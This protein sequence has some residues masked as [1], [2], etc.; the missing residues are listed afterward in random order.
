MDIE[1]NALALIVLDRLLVGG[2]LAQLGQRRTAA[3]FRAIQES[4]VNVMRHAN[5]TRVSVEVE[6]GACE[7]LAVVEDD[8]IGIG[9]GQLSQ[10]H[11][12]GLRGMRERLGALGGSVAVSSSAGAG[13][14][15]EI[16]LP[17]RDELAPAPTGRA[18]SEQ[19]LEMPIW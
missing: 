3:V 18:V 2:Q 6:I 10:V 14:R 12:F 1:R 8:G 4:L 9:P 7:L 17:I 13:T 16:R 19:Q 11:S 5:A 15:V